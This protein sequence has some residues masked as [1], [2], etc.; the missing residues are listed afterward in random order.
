MRASDVRRTLRDL[1]LRPSRRYGQSFLLRGGVARRMAEEAG[2]GSVLEVGPGLGALT[3]ELAAGAE[4]LCCVEVAPVL[5]DYLRGRED[6]ADVSIVTGDFLQTDPAG[7]PGYPFDVLASNL[8][9]SI[10]SPA[11]LRLTQ[12]CLSAVRRAVVMLQR[13]VAQRVTAEPG[14]GDYG[15]LTLA[16]WPRFEAETLLDAEPRDFY[17][18][19]AVR[20]RVLI[21]RRRDV[22]KVPPETMDRF[23]WLVRVGFSS[24]RKTLLN[25][26]SAVMDRGAA[27][28]LLSEAGISRRARAEELAPEVLA[29]IAG[30][31]EP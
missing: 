30:R 4:S 5:A 3:T 20:S 18:Q 19:P 9:Y 22:P 6:L 15:R 26:L 27:A 23:S 13:E 17:P 8:P 7:L 28:A 24:R 16:L 11:L 21:L 12:P 31:L 29:G 10:S 14:C 2:S 1:E 25:N